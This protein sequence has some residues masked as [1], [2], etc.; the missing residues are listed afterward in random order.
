[1]PGNDISLVSFIDKAVGTSVSTDPT[2]YT[3]KE[4]SGRDSSSG[5]YPTTGTI[6]IDMNVIKGE[7]YTPVFYYFIPKG[8]Q[9]YTLTVTNFILTA[10]KIYYEDADDVIYL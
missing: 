8:S 5:A 7:C 6:T 10:V 2:S 3:G 4:F 1:M 9:S